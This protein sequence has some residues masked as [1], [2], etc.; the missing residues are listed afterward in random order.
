MHFRGESHSRKPRVAVRVAAG[1]ERLPRC[2]QRRQ[3][4]AGHVGLATWRS[5][6]L[7]KTCYAM[8]RICTFL[9]PGESHWSILSE[10]NLG[11]EE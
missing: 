9:N 10:Y 11:K 5:Q 3:R 1:G 7:S 2:P 4:E 8:W 6:N